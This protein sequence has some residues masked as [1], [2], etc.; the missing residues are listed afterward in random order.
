MALSK[1]VQDPGTGDHA[2]IVDALMDEGEKMLL[3][4]IAELDAV[5]WCDSWQGSL[6]MVWRLSR[7]KTTEV[8]L[9]NISIALNESD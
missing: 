4:V 1:L 6:Q 2:C 5:R 3:L 7:S 8:A 9:H